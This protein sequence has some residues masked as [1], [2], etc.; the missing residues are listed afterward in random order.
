[1]LKMMKDFTT[2]SETSATIDVEDEETLAVNTMTV[3]YSKFPPV[4]M[5]TPR[6]P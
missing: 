3:Y 4:Q 1:M 5:R 2:E 6:F